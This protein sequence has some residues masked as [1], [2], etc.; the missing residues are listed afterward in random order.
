MSCAAARLAKSKALV[1][2]RDAAAD[3]SHLRRFELAEKSILIGHAGAHGVDHVHAYDHV[4]SWGP[5]GCEKED[6]YEKNC[7]R[8]APLYT[9]QPVLPDDCEGAKV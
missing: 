8:P 7:N 1:V 2:V 9:V 4:L 5:R 6:R 3:D